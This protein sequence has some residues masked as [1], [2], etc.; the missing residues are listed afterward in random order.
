[1]SDDAHSDTNDMMGWRD[2]IGGQYAVLYDANSYRIET[3]L[4]NALD[5]WMWN[6]EFR[7]SI[8]HAPSVLELRLPKNCA[9]IVL[10]TSMEGSTSRLIWAGL[11]IN[12]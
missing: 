7:L 9:F 4:C 8:Q 2:E 1:M 5:L 3:W 12:G 11:D 10:G 6:V